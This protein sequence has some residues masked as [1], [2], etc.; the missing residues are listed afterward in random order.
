MSDLVNTNEL[1]GKIYSDGWRICSGGTVEVLE[2]ATG[3]TLATVGV[4]SS[5][6]VRAAAARAHHAQRS[7]RSVPALERSELFRR[8]ATLLTEHTDEATRWLV[9]EGGSTRQKAAAEISA[10]LDEMWTAAALPMQPHGKLLPSEPARRSIARRVPVGV[11]GVISP[12]NFPMLLGVRAVAP[13]L[14]LGNAVVLKPD[15]NTPVSGGFLLSAI[16]RSAGLPEDVLHIVPGDAET[17]EAVTANPDVHMIAFTGSTE[18]GRKV[19][20]VAGRALKR[21]SLELGGNNALI[22]LEDADL[23]LAAAA[24]AMGTFFHQGQVCMASGRHIVVESI[25][26]EYV[27]ELTRRAEKLTLGDPWTTEASLG[28]LINEAQLQRVDRIVADSVAANAELRTGGHDHGLYYRPTVLANI[29]PSMP[30]FTEEIFGPVAP[31]IV[32]VDAEEAVTLANRTEYGL[33][34]AVHTGSVARGLAIAEQL[35]AGIVHVNDQTISDNAVVPFGGTGA[36][37][38]GTRYGA[39][40][41]WDNFTEWQWLT[42]NQ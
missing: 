38:N 5:D 11:V 41:S 18:V 39:D 25:A 2:P 24:G 15:I 36:S 6:D 23:E 42:V 21:H 4:A 10:V 9:R 7:W 14:A 37:G 20:A 17:G 13:A 12:W 1:P 40:H 26:D 8:A 34:A 3:T 30:A 22:V 28:P 35:D 19:G 29:T 33:V 31:V 16:L 27:N 32:V